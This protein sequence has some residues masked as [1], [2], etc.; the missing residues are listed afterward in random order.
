M[1]NDPQSWRHRIINNPVRDNLNQCL[2][3]LSSPIGR[4]VN[5]TLMLI[6]IFSVIMGMMGSL[7]DVEQ[8]WQTL[9][10]SFEYGITLV[11]I[12]EYVLRLYSA[13]RPLAYAFSIYGIIDLAT[14]LPLLIFGDSNTVIRLLRVF[15]L[16]KL[17][18]YLRALQ[19]FVSSLKDVFEIMVVVLAAII[20]IVLVA[21]NLIY[22]LEPQ[23]INDAFEGCWWAL[24]TMT[25]VGYGDI[26]PHSPAGRL[27]ASSLIIMGVT[28]F[29][30][31]TGTISVKVNH[32]VSYNRQCHECKRKMVQEFIY[33]PYCGSHQQLKQHKAMADKAEKQPFE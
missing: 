7:K 27:L 12:F 14:L 28:I 8:Q 32:V 23:N 3:D 17:I 13:R 25:T 15:R 2:F 21:G 6:I 24:V 29:A 22:F 4:K 18:R 30:M 20:I 26:V 1:P 33:C 16:L 19:L 31:L 5:Q 11:F 9:F 10:H